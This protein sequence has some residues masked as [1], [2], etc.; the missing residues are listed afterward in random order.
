M[1]RSVVQLDLR[2]AGLG[3]V[4]LLYWPEGEWLYVAAEASKARWLT[5]IRRTGGAW[6]S[7][8]P[9]TEPTW[10]ALEEVTDGRIRDSVRRGIDARYGT[11][12]WDKYFGE[13]AVV[14]RLRPSAAPPGS[15][16]MDRAVREFDA[17]AGAYDARMADQPF[18]RYLKMIAAAELARTFRGIDPLLE[19]GPG[20]GYHTIPLLK[21]GHRIVAVDVSEG[22]L[23]QLRANANLSGVGD[24]LTTL[25]GTVQSAAPRLERTAGAPFGG[26]YSLFGPFNIDP[27]PAAMVTSLG[28][29]MGPGGLVQFTS[30]NRPGGLAPLWEVLNGSP[31]AALIRFHRD[32]PAHRLRYPLELHLRNPQDWDRLF[33]PKF[34]PRGRRSLSALTPPFESPRLM[35]RTSPESRKLWAAADAWVGRHPR[36]WFAGEWS[37]LT[38]ERAPT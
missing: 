4:P 8:S 23:A 38:Y 21:A 30:L 14:A 29:L 17:A 36:L 37:L 12:E 22:M 2:D 15:G 9:G 13:T 10:H 24:R 35:G 34:V 1:P 33:E 31:R 6:V 3:W 18:E 27:D 32:V 16:A 11:G 19:I 5:A 20:T 25:A 28:G 26:A 7:L